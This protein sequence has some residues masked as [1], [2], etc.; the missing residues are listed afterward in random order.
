MSCKHFENWV[1]S[2]DAFEEDDSENR[3]HI[4]NCKMCSDLFAVDQALENNI[5]AT[6]KPVELPD[7]LLDRINISIDQSSHHHTP[8][9]K[10]MA[11][12][13]A[14]FF[15]LG[16]ILTAGFFISQP[17]RYDNLQQLGESAVARHLEGNTHMTFTAND[18]EAARVMMSNALKFNVIL[19]DLKDQGFIPLGGRLC[20][21]GKCKTAY[22]F[23]EHQKKI[24]SLFILD[25][26]HLDFK[27]SESSRF[28][29]TIKGFQTRIWKEND[30]VYAMVF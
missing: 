1:L 28:I 22:L 3:R 5:K 20:V 18:I 4:D 6:M 27:L 25:Y 7:K 9:K 2:K 30:Q 24:C 17:F 21:V 10:R 19:P 16:A 14:S 13:L 11:L 23:Y 29:N 12:L 15:I 26:D 8:K